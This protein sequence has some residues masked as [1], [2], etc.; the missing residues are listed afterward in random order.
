MKATEILSKA[1]EL[2][3]IETEV[4]LAQATL[5]NGTVIEAD[6]MAAGKEVFIVTE[7]L[8]ALQIVIQT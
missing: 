6:E 8:L 4:K 3:S 7:D 1:K 5:E 2:L